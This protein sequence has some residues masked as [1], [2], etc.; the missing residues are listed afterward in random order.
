MP[1][2]V[3]RNPASA[4]Q[5]FPTGAV[6]V[7]GGVGAAGGTGGG[8]VEPAAAAVRRH[9]QRRNDAGDGEEPGGSHSEHAAPHSRP[10]T[11]ASPRV[12]AI[13]SRRRVGPAGSRAGLR[14]PGTL[15]GLASASGLLHGLAL[16]ARA[17]PLR[18]APGKP[19]PARRVPAMASG[20]LRTARP[21]PAPPRRRRPPPAACLARRSRLRR[22]ERHPLRR[23]KL[24]FEGHAHSWRSIARAARH[25]AG[26]RI[27]GAPIASPC[28]PSP[29]SRVPNPE[30]RVPTAYT[31]SRK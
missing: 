13:P 6:G 18:A 5:A 3:F 30:T 15:L 17:R 26:V 25:A 29:E 1:C 16:S 24:R 20:L 9:Q 8:D 23:G 7:V 11:S 19:P 10:L 12:A 27:V 22:T 31:A 14:R 2:G 28:L 21:P 4:L